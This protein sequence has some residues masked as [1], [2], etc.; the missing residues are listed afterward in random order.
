M[1]TPATTTS[2]QSPEEE[3][4]EACTSTDEAFMKQE[5][6]EK[7]TWNTWVPQKNESH[8]ENPLPICATS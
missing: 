7:N 5:Q 8:Y 4:P 2:Q 3:T 1:S 6:Q